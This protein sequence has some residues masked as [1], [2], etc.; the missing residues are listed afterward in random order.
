MGGKLQVRKM[1]IKD[2]LLVLGR[3]ETQ[4]IKAKSV[5]VA[6]GSRVEGVLVADK[7]DVG[8]SHYLV[9]WEKGWMGQIARAK[10]LGRMTRVD[11]V[12]ADYVYL[13][14]NTRSERIFARIVEVGDG[15]IVE[16]ISYTDN[17]RGNLDRIHVEK[18]PEKVTSLP[19]PPL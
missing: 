10:L 3:I 16:E 6:S 2:E 1:T 5:K 8:E 15:A 4:G 9:D 11:D 14:N 17:L 7:V 13:G 18:P 19:A 12:Y